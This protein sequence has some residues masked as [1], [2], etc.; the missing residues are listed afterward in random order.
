M[1]ITVVGDLLLDEDIDGTIDRLC[2]D[3]PV[4][5]V[6]VSSRTVRAGGAGLVA[7]MLR[8]DGHETELVTALSDD[9]RASVLRQE[10]HDV[11]VVASSSGAPTPTKTRIRS[12][13]QAICR[14]DDGCED[15]PIPSV[16]A[17]MIAAIDSADAIVVSD[18]GRRLTEQPAVREALERRATEVPLVWDPHPRGTAPVASTR[19][20]TPNLVEAARTVGATP[21]PHRA[22]EIAA[23]LCEQYGR[24][25][26]LVTLG[27]R[28]AVLATEDRPPVD[29]VTRPV[30]TADACGAGDR[31]IASAAI[32]LASGQN[33]A[34]ASQIA[35]DQA[36]DYLASGG[37]AG[38][39]IPAD[40][41]APGVGAQSALALASSI[42]ARGGTV[43]AA[44]GC[45]DLLHAGHV[46]LLESARDLGDC[47]IVCLN[48]DQ[49]VRRLKGPERP[50][51]SEQDRVEMLSAL[52][53]VD[54]V[55][56]FD[57]DSPERILKEL[58]PDYWVKGGDYRADTLPEASVLAQWGGTAVTFP[59]QLAHST[60]Q[61]AAAIERVS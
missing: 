41:G 1:R 50:I 34:A 42:R 48:S 40:P 35:V 58:R 12:G 44:G 19:L 13:T 46:R 3:A 17:E 49:S 56:V 2:P 38:L 26:V 5:V 28:G 39:E 31:L 43:I 15:P 33:L 8:R 9:A 57:D 51:I 4:P 37:V 36:R 29:I 30:Q 27:E 47:L 52:T 25:A 60:T 59:Y 14:V 11:A 61:L 54:A 23:K 53:C 21:N 32:A 6:A 55:L 16:T 45:F 18:Y 20:V 7:R 22:A 24:V 10:L